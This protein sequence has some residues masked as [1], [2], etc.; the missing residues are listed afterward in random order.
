MNERPEPRY[1]V[2]DKVIIADKHRIR[3]CAF[4]A[5]DKMYDYIGEE[6]VVK[7]VD[8]VSSRKVYR[9][10]LDVDGSAWLW[11]ENCLEPY[12][13]CPDLPEFEPSSILGLF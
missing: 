3:K 12:E 2:G 10:K 11:C 4:S 8:W 1:K 7:S 9:Y 5:T 13:T 6:A